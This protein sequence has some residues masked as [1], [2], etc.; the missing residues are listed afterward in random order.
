MAAECLR[1][2]MLLTELRNKK[3]KEMSV[4][5]SFAATDSISVCADPA[6]RSRRYLPESFMFYIMM[7]K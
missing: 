5:V 6:S 4:R 2:D 7:V 1:L 3:V